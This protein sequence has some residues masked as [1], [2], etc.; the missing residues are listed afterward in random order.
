MGREER[1]REPSKVASYLAF[2]GREEGAGVL[3]RGLAGGE[4][5]IGRG[6]VDSGWQIVEPGCLFYAGVKFVGKVPATLGAAVAVEDAKIEDLRIA[7]WS[8]CTI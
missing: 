8:V 3:G 7:A 6:R 4:I 1:R 2:V 5:S